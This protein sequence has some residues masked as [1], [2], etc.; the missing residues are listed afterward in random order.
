MSIKKKTEEKMQKVIKSFEEK[1]KVFLIGYSKLFFESLNLKGKVCGLIGNFAFIEKCNNTNEFIFELKDDC[2]NGVME[3]I[4]VAIG[5]HG[6]ISII[7]K[8]SLKLTIPQNI[9][10][11]EKF[12][13]ELDKK[14]DEAKESL[15]SIRNTMRK[16]HCGSKKKSDEEIQNEKDIDTVS[17]NLNKKID[18]M[19]ASIMK[20]LAHL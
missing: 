8:K 14:R 15:R 2:T 1:V 17:K 11:K 4:K 6:I 20:K 7:D 19:H 16:E 10:Y 3:C 13:Q 5:S 9:S 18:D 12:G